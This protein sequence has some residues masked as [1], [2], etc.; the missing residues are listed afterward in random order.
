MATLNLKVIGRMLADE[1]MIRRLEQQRPRLGQR[2]R[3][4]EVLD[5]GRSGGRGRD[6]RPEGTVGHGLGAGPDVSPVAPS[7]GAGRDPDGVVL[8]RVEDL[9]FEDGGEL[10]R[11]VDFGAG[12]GDDEAALSF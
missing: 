9:V 3:I 7:A 5:I 11:W 2:R 12:E 4:G 10:G 8:G 1:E 6:L